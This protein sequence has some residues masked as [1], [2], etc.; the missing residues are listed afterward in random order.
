MTVR[1]GVCAGRA[2][3][4][5]VCVADGT[6]EVLRRGRE[7]CGLAANT[8]FEQIIEALAKASNKAVAILRFAGAVIPF[9]AK[10]I[11]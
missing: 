1:L 10:V 11:I 8:R 6:I 7:S 3:G 2:T 9:F 5:G 4:V